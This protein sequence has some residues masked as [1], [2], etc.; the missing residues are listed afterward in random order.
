MT[1]NII[2]YGFGLDYLKN[3]GIKQALREIYQNF[4]DYGE[5]EETVEVVNNIALVTISND[6]QPESLDFL[7]IGNS[8]KGNNLEAIGKHGEGMKMAFLI[9]FRENLTSSITTPK[10]TICPSIY[11]DK[12]IGDC[13]SL[14]YSKNII[15]NNGFSISFECP[16]D[17]F[18]DFK[19]GV[20]KE[21]D[22]IFTDNYHGSIVDKP[23]GNIF[24]GGL[25]VCQLENF[26]KAFNFPPSR[27]PLDRDREVPRVWDVNWHAA[28]IHD[29]HGKW[30]AKDTTYD[31]LQYVSVIPQTI[32]EKYEPVKVGN[33]IE[34]VTKNEAGETV[35]L[36][37]ES[38]KKELAKDSF[39][40][41]LIKKIKVT[42][43]KHLG[44]YER[45]MYLLIVKWHK[46]LRLY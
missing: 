19:N 3:W 20:L 7:R 34:F 9:F 35:V 23:I 13:F 11:T 46:I 37:N 42:M 15:E 21:E 6:W 10:Y 41:K 5:Y 1:D 27:I 38:I 17:I 4:L 8:N 36:K 14:V 26:S 29:A 16:Y 45:N 44:L 32:K 28:R 18:Q 22:Y 39:F 12:E 43:M 24:V 31:D 33:S 30:E 25:Y 2:H 40:S